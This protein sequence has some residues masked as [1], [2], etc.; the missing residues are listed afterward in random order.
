MVSELS[1]QGWEGGRATGLPQGETESVSGCSYSGIAPI[2]RNQTG[3][4]IVVQPGA[5]AK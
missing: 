5:M 1:A 2:Y 4:D 3:L